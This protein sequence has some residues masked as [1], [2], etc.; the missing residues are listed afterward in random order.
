MVIYTGLPRFTK[1]RSR[2][3]KGSP[4]R[5]EASGE[6]RSFGVTVEGSSAN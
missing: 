5:A 3:V 6:A 2:N 1:Q 4:E